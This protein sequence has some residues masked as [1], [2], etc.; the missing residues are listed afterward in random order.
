MST[1]A[2]GRRTTLPI[3]DAQYAGP[4]LYDAKDPDAKFPPIE[5]AQ[6]A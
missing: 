3:P 5:T 1:Q 6:A 2:D 4:T